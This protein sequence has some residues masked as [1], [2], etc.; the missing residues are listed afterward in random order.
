LSIDIDGNDYWVWERISCIDP[1]IVVVEYNATFGARKQLSVPYRS[2]F[3]RSQAHFSNLYYG[4]SLQALNQLGSARGYRFV[5]CNRAGNN[6]YFVKKD[7]CDNLNLPTVTEGF[8]QSRFQEGRDS[9]GNLI[10]RSVTER[11]AAIAHLPVQ[12][13]EHDETMPL[14]S[15]LTQES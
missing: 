2:D 10:H 8:V 1:V 5:G 9:D 4:A 11:V 14:G 12:D 3:S 7:R 6:A 13:L 15:I